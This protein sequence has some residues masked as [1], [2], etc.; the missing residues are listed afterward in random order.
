MAVTD[1]YATL[2]QYKAEFK[3][4]D[5]ADDTPVTDTL[6]AV[7]RLLDRKLGRFFTQE[8]AATRLYMPSASGIPT[9]PNWAESENPYKYGGLTRLLYIDDLVSVTTIKIDEDRD[10][11]FTDETALAT[12]DYELLPRNAALGSEPVPYNSIELTEWGTKFAWPTGC[13]VQIV[14]TFGWPAVPKAIQVATIHLAGIVRLSSP[15][16]SR[17]IPEGLDQFVETSRQ[18]QDIIC[19][20]ERHYKRVR[21]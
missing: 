11:V 17:R 3:K 7:S 12:T 16:A 15:R 6:A 19:D 13:R 2:A 9:R 1:S 4:T 21:L 5:T 8:S 10:G 18:A 14:G 20:L